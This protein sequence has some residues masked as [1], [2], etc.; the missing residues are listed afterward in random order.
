MKDWRMTGLHR[1][2]GGCVA[3]ELEGGKQEMGSECFLL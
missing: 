3:H 1:G 2:F